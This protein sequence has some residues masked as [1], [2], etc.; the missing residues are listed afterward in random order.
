MDF[1]L[2]LDKLK[3]ISHQEF[4]SLNWLPV[5]YTFKQ[6]INSIFLIILNEK[7]SNYLNKVF[8]VA[9]VNNFQLIVFKNLKCPFCK[10]NTN[11]H[12]L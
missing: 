9:I 3:H 1:F 7:C 12:P 5:T 8:H 4:E 6:C 11:Q 10:T 2:Q